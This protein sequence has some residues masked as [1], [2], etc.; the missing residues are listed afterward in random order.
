MNFRSYLQ[1]KGRARYK[2]SSFII[3]TSD[4]NNYQK[5][6]EFFQEIQKHLDIVFIIIS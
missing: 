1:M 5:R 6:Y 4:E 2:D 3:L